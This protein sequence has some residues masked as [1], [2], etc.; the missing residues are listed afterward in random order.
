LDAVRGSLAGQ[1]ER[2]GSS[3]EWWKNTRRKAWKWRTPGV[4][5]LGVACQLLGRR[6]RSRSSGSPNETLLEMSLEIRAISYS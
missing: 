2:W 6:I 3:A 5:T 1:K 4:I